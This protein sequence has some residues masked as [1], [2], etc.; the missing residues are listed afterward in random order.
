MKIGKFLVAGLLVW[1]TSKSV[2]SSK[3]IPTDSMS[4]LIQSRIKRDDD[5]HVK[6][7]QSHTGK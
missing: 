1:F 7:Q 5:Y 4:D 3:I 2:L 6:C